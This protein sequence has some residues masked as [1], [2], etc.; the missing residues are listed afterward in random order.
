MGVTLRKN[1]GSGF[2]FPLFF[3]NRS[4]FKGDAIQKKSST[5]IPHANNGQKKKVKSK[6]DEC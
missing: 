2:P 5:I 4:A 1:Y 3:L 6:P